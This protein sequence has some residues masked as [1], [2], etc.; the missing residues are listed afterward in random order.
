MGQVRTAK[1]RRKCSAR[2]D[3]ATSLLLA[4]HRT[5]R[6]GFTLTE[7]LVVLLIVG[8]LMGIS[9]AALLGALPTSREAATKALIVRIHR[10]VQD[11][12]SSMESRDIPVQNIDM[13]L[14]GDSGMDPSAVPLRALVIAKKR[15]I[16]EEFPQ[17]F[18]VVRNN[19]GDLVRHSTTNE[20][21]VAGDWDPLWVD[22]DEDGVVDWVQSGSVSPVALSYRQTINKL[23]APAFDN[24]DNDLDG[25]TDEDDETPLVHHRWETTRSECLYLI[26]TQGPGASSVNADSF[27]ASEVADTDGDGLMEFVDAWG[28]PLRWYRWSAG[29]FATSQRGWGGYINTPPLEQREHDPEDPNNLLILR[30][31]WNMYR[32]PLAQWWGMNHYERAQ[33]VPPAMAQS[34]LAPPFLS[35]PAFHTVTDVVYGGDPTKTWNAHDFGNGTVAPNPNYGLTAWSWR[36]TPPLIVS[37]GPD[38]DFGIWLP[39]LK[40]P[41]LAQMWGLPPNAGLE[42]R[43]RLYRQEAIVMPESWPGFQILAQNFPGIV[44]DAHLDNLSNLGAPETLQ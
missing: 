7:L 38:E 20:P 2:S 31:W 5:A 40:H 32:P 3:D 39:G 13:R 17:W 10:G 18:A 35:A 23:L 19:A 44:L 15:L 8:I 6:A 30:D 24:L 34:G 1:G 9:L 21:F 28:T 26:I 37:A 29:F 36:A 14:A 22:L 43:D 27:R 25:Q 33:S 4:S 42:A 16:K 41:S 12:L 11:R